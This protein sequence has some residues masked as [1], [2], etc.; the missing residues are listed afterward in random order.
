MRAAA[1]GE[2]GVQRLPAA[3]A[4]CSPATATR[5]KALNTRG[6][7]L[8]FSN[9]M[10]ILGIAAIGVLIVYQA[11]LTT[12]IQLYIIGVFVSFSLGQ[13]GMVRH[14]RRSLRELA[15]TAAGCRDAGVRG[16]RAPLG[17][18]RARRSTPLGARHDRLRAADRDDHE[19]HARRVPG[20]H[21]DPDPRDP[22]DRREPLLPRRRARDRDRRPRRTSARRATSRSSWSTACRSPSSRRSTTRSPP[23]TTRRSPCTSPSSAEESDELQQQWAEHSIPMPLVIIESPYRTFAQPRR[24]VHQ[25][26]PREARLLGRHRLPAAVHRRPLVGVAPAQPPRAAHREPAHAHPRRLDHARA[27]AARLVRAHLRP[28]LPTAAR[29]GALRPARRSAGASPPRPRSRPAGPPDKSVAGEPDKSVAGPP[30]S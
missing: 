21:R 24:A 6:D 8:V 29:A 12:L 22:H 17:A 18:H 14:W 7:R 26:V 28:P 2:H 15:A 27:V 5:P 30:Q 13:I 19:V 4:R 3:R 11:N 20:V 10:I 9:G 25:A 1:R 23:S 16:I